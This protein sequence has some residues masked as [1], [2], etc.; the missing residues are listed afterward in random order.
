MNEMARLVEACLVDPREGK[1]IRQTWK[2]GNCHI[3]QSMQDFNSGIMSKNMEIN[4]E[5]VKRFIERYRRADGERL[6][7]FEARAVMRWEALKAVYELVDYGPPDDK[8][9]PATPPPA[10][11]ETEAPR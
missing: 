11:P 1:E 3:S 7:E 5:A 2:C 6:S 9:R 10:E 8:G 4:D